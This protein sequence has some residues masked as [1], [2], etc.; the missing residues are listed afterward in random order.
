MAVDEGP[1]R[2]ISYLF[3][4]FRQIEADIGPRQRLIVDSVEALSVDT[5][6]KNC[7]L[8][9]QSERGKGLDWRQGRDCMLSVNSH[10]EVERLPDWV[11]SR[12][13]WTISRQG[14]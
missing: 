8:T 13:R 9:R 4:R 10:I 14:Y 12:S 2:R 11:R 5:D 3:P 6:N 1:E 7:S